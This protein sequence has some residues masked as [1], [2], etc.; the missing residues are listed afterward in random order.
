M[1]CIPHPTP[2]YGQV[3][4]DFCGQALPHVAAPP[5]RPLFLTRRI[6]AI[7]EHESFDRVHWGVHKE[8]SSCHPQKRLQPWRQSQHSAVACLLLAGLALRCWAF[9]RDLNSIALSAIRG[10]T[11][12]WTALSRRGCKR[13]RFR[14]PVPA[15]RRGCLCLNGNRARER[16]SKDLSSLAAR[17]RRIAIGGAVELGALCSAPCDLRRPFFPALFLAFQRLAQLFELLQR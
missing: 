12:T 15:I 17:R 14:Q 13:P 2:Y 1:C 8:F 4:A 9:E 10:M 6:P 16:V 3:I 5:Q 11:G 7:F